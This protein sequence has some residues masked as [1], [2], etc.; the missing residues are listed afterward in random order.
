[1]AE[2]L[3]HGVVVLR[4]SCNVTIVLVQEVRNE[5]ILVKIKV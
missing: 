1:M 5:N 4:Q 2:I 3:E